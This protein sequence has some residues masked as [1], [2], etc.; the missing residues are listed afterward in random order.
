MRKLFILIF[1]LSVVYGVNAQIKFGLKGGVNSSAIKLDEVITVS[2]EEKYS[3]EGLTERTIGFHVGFML[4]VTFF[5][6]FIQP[7]LLFTST[8]GE[9]QVKD[10]PGFDPTKLEWTETL[11]FKKLDFPVMVGYKFGPARL[12]LGPVASFI[13]SSKADLFDAAGYEEKYK[14]TTFG[15]QA[16]VGID[17][18]KKVTFDFRYEGNLSKLGD[19]MTIGD[20]DFNFDSRPDQLIF[21]L[22]IFF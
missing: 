10:I 2:G 20:E 6:A 1:C 22:G 21:S 8:G 13:I 5:G 17:I 18:L 16:G 12:Q 11:E 9:V 19:G 14:S 3:L 4:R 7:E 15:Y